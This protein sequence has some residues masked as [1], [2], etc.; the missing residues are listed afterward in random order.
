MILAQQVP[1]FMGKH[2]SEKPS[3]LKAELL[4]QN[5]ARGHQMGTRIHHPVTTCETHLGCPLV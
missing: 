1:N 3:G 2:M 4:W 5:V